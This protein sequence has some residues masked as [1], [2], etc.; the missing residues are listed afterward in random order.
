MSYVVGLGELMLRLSSLSNERLLQTSMLNATFGGVEANVCV[1]VARFGG[2]ARFV[3]AFPDNAV[4]R[5]AEELLLG[6]K[7]DTSCIVWKGKRIGVYFLDTGYDHRQSSVIY[8]RENSA[9]SQ[10]SYNDFDW[11]HIFNDAEY[12]HITGITPGISESARELTLHAVKEAKKR[13]VKV[14]CDINYRKKL[15]KYGKN[16]WDVMPEIVK[17]TDI[18]FAN[19]YDVVKILGIS[20]DLDVDSEINDD[21]YTNLML[22]AIKEY[23]LS[24]VITTKRKVLSSSHNIFSSK[25]IA[26]G[27]LYKSKSYDINNI[28]D[29]VGTGDAF[30]GGILGGFYIFE[31]IQDVLNFA[32]A[33]SCIKHTIYGDWNLVT[34]EEVINLMKSSGSADVSR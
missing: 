28:V 12:F 7:V 16:I 34:K 27:K 17:Y 24:M 13:N 22:K 10:I 2:N 4:S 25:C 19:E 33:A 15:W 32:T 14:S 26:N 23:D 29:R 30:V 9:I 18:L 1:S 8:D 5:K 20:S 11:N 3:T 31:D 6:Q 21:D